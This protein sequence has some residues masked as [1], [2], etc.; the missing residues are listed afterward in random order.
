MASHIKS[1]PNNSRIN[2][3]WFLAGAA[4]GAMLPVAAHAAG[5]KKKQK[6]G[7]YADEAGKAKEDLEDKVAD[8][9]YQSDVLAQWIVDIWTGPANNPLITPSTGSPSLSEYLARSA[10]A[11]AALAARGI[12]L[13]KPIVIT[14]DEYDAGF[15]LEEAG[16]DA[17]IGVVFVLPRPTRPTLAGPPLLETAKMLMAITPN[18]I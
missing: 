12:H 16:L 1:Q 14:E 18:G 3:R 4:G 7:I 8:F 10:A 2:R 6:R 15:S 17:K 9:S 5:S 11:K 13:E